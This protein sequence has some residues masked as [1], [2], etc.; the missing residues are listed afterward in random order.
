MAINL[1]DLLDFS[2]GSP[3][4]VIEAPRG[5]GTI[6]I[7]GSRASSLGQ[8]AGRGLAAFLQKRAAREQSEQQ[9]QAQV[10]AAQPL[11]KALEAIDHPVVQAF[12][13]RGLES[14]AANREVGETLLQTFSK[15]SA[16]PQ[17]SKPFTRIV[18]GDDPLNERLGLGLQPGERTRVELM[19]GTDGGIELAGGVVANPME[20]NDGAAQPFGGGVE[21]SSLNIIAG[22][23]PKLRQ[24]EASEEER[25][26]FET[27]V[28]EYTQ[29][30]PII[31]PVTNRPMV[32]P[33]T[34]EPMTVR[35]ELP[36]FARG[37]L[38]QS[39]PGA[40]KPRAQPK[41]IEADTTQEY[42]TLP[43]DAQIPPPDPEGVGGRA[44]LLDHVLAGDVTGPI[45]SI[46]RFASRVPGLGVR[47]DEERSAAKLMEGMTTR[48]TRALRTNPRFVEGERK[49]L[50]EK[51]GLNPQVFD[52]PQAFAADMAGIDQTL[53]LI[54]SEMRQVVEGR[55]PMVTGETRGLAADTLHA[56]ENYRKIATPPRIESEQQYEEFAQSAPPGTRYMAQDE[57]G[58]WQIYEV[59]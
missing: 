55:A 26:L 43:E 20:Q 53:E 2:K 31:D 18:S 8:S 32:D 51:I 10:E 11:M 7:G 24:G 4:R 16:K 23:A 15:E 21:G 52:T 47:A 34:G 9:A 13:S 1:E 58:N 14:V 42:T 27:A 29:A 6:P 30:R 48:L 40:P 3:G 39:T 5:S 54:E 25:R 46:Q 36:S 35:N 57:D 22:V 38:D 59:E 19:R 56:I 17:E 44:T 50:V 45:P 28:T 12:V 49:E 37:L 41:P 33:Q